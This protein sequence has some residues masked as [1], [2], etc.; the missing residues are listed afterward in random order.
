[1][2]RMLDLMCEHQ[3]DFL[4][5]QLF[6]RQLPSQVRA[7]LANPMITD[8][9]RL[10]EEAD[11]YFLAGQERCMAAFFQ[12]CVFTMQSLDRRLLNAIRHAVSAGWET[13]GPALGRL[14]P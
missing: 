9:R 5:V 6:L 4:F 13:P 14:W 12:A 10:A 1:M 11:T 3:P 7:V 8:C 2:D